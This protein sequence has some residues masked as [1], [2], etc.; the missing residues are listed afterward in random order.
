M[1]WWR[2]TTA[3]TTADLALLDDTETRRLAR[4]RSLAGAAEFAG[5]R[6]SVR[7]VLGGLLGTPPERIR[8]GRRVC[9]GCGDP[10][11]GPPAVLDPQVEWWI[12]V[13]HTS[14]CGMLAVSGV[15]VGVDVER[16]RDIRVGDLSSVVLTPSEAGWLDGLA[17]DSLRQ[18]FLRCWTR[19]E[20]AL[21]AV[22]VGITVP[23]NRVETH[24]GTVGT[25]TVSTGVPGTPGTWSVTDLPIPTPWT[26]SVAVPAGT[27]GPVR[28]R[29]LTSK[30]GLL[31]EKW[32]R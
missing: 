2:G 16:A 7:R 31:P 4:I 10:E 13:S 32:S 26:A 22:G 3:V 14:G 24:P 20:A 23:L 12:S 1:W 17:G 19:K 8:L 9:P 25:V 6:A 21:K 27:A 11:H 30:A 5:N 29:A 18:A 28:L 15:P